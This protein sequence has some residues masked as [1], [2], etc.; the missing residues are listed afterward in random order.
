MASF[1]PPPVTPFY[2]WDPA[3]GASHGE[4]AAHAG[5]VYGVAVHPSGRLAAS[6][7]ADAVV[8]LWDPRT[9]KQLQRL[10]GHD[11]AVTDVKFASDGHFLASAS[12]DRTV[13]LWEVLSPPPDEDGDR[14]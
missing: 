6:A 3:A 9:G 2:L 8:R 10:T 7:G 1:S 14:G 13:R 5:L 4:V 12:A 11:A